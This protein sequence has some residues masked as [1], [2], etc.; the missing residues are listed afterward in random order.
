MAFT[1]RWTT[2]SEATLDRDSQT[3]TRKGEIVGK[4]PYTGGMDC[5]DY[6]SNAVMSWVTTNLPTYSTPFGL[7]YLNSI[8]LSEHY[9]AQHYTFSANYSPINKMTGTY[10]ITVD[11]AVGNVH[12]TAGR[13]IA[14]YDGTGKCPDNGGV[15]FDG[16][17]ITGTEIPVAE[18]SI[19]VSYRHPQAYLIAS[20][21]RSIGR[22]RGYPNSDT[23]LGYDPGEVMYMGGNFTQTDAEASASYSFKISPNATNLVIGGCT[24][25]EK[26]G[27]DA[28]SPTYE[29]KDWTAG[30]GTKHATKVV[31]GIEIIRPEGREW[32]AYKTTFGWG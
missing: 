18:D 20:Y 13:R 27:F 22:L 31:K 12:I 7:L 32:K 24:V 3:R 8:Q 26:K 10:Q 17:E 6:I 11:Q 15:F 2:G 5:F 16:T 30:D 1:I 29:M 9:Y 25:V 21:I 28:I 14:G 23:F 19:T 4:L